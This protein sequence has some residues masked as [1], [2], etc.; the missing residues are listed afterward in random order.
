MHD[1]TG[2]LCTDEVIILTV[3]SSVDYVISYKVP[4][5]GEGIGTNG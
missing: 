5:K 2:L 3:S 4:A 1:P